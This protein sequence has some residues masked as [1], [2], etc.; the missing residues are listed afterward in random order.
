MKITCPINRLRLFCVIT[1]TIFGWMIR[2]VSHAARFAQ[3]CACTVRFSKYKYIT[4]SGVLKL[5]PVFFEEGDRGGVLQ[6]DGTCGLS[7]KIHRSPRQNKHS[8][9]TPVIFSTRTVQWLYIFFVSRHAVGNVSDL[10]MKMTCKFCGS[11]CVKT[12]IR[13][14]ANNAINVSTVSIK[15]F[16]P[17]IC[18]LS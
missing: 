6:T 8:A 12:D 17:L 5:S 9:P 13:K 18:R 4:S 16:L 2:T 7:T 1:I 3:H 14:T 10:G 11:I 15:F